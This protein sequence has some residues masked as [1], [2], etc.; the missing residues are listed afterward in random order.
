MQTVT[1]TGYF[2]VVKTFSDDRTDEV[3]VTLTCNGG[4]PLQ[5]SFTIAGGDPAGV[6][7]VVTELPDGGANCEVTET[8]SPDNYTVVM[9]DGAGCS[10]PGFVGGMR[11]WFPWLHYRP[12]RKC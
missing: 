10:W 8:G 9:N 1:G 6:T 4:I 5:Q 12:S 2:K 3:E 7:F 11:G